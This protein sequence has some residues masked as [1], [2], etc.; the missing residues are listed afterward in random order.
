MEKLVFWEMNEIN[1]E[2]VSYYTKQGKLSNWKK[3]IDQHG[4][5]TT[6]SEK[7]YEELEPWIQWPTVRTGLDYAEHKVFRLG[8][9]E[10]CGIRQ[11]WEILEERGLKVAALSPINGANKTKYSPFWIP[12]PWVDTKISG[13]AFTHRISKA[14]RQAVNDNSQEKLSAETI[15]AV[16]EGLLTKT[17]LKSWGTYFKGVVGALKKQHWSKALVLDRLLAD[18][19]I[20]LWKKHQPDFSVLFLN[21]GAHTQ[22]HYMCSS[23]AYTGNAKNPKWYIPEG[24]DPLLE[25]LELY[26]SILAELTALPNTRLMIS[27]GMRQVPYEKVA[28]YWRLKNHGDFLKKIGV[29]Y[30]CVQPRMTRD[31]LIVFDTIDDC[32]KAERI[33]RTVTAENGVK[34]FGEIDNRGVDLFVTLTYQDEIQNSFTM[35]IDN[36]EYLGF[37]Q[38]VVFVAIKNGHHDTLGYFFDSGIHAGELEQKFPLKSIFGMVMHHFGF[39]Y[40]NSKMVE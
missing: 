14:V 30:T 18:V 39:I 10:A 4:I 38:D 7:K 6:Q 23:P 3:F 40:E 32:Q 36:Q 22:H 8:D 21:A 9:M 17:Q 28:Y 16:I 27:V 5:Y 1:F 33:L 24:A 34:V 2:F 13:D 12:D 29:R 35:K 11:H 37:K 19:F 15:V 20:S 31:F 26:D 25:I